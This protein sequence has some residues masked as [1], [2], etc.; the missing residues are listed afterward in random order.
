MRIAF[1][2]SFL[3]GLIKQAKVQQ[4]DPVKLAYIHGRCE[5]LNSPNI[6]AGFD[7]ALASYQGVVKK[8]TFAVALRP[9]VLA[10]AVEQVVQE[11]CGPISE[12]MRERLPDHI[13]LTEMYKEAAAQ[14]GRPAPD[15]F[16]SRFQRMKLSDKLAL[17]SS[18]GGATGAAA[19]TFFPSQADD[20]Y[21]RGPFSRAVR[22]GARGFGATAGG[23]LGLLAGNELGNR[24]DPTGKPHPLA[25]LAGA[26]IGGLAG[27]Q[28]A[29][30]VF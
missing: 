26:G 5:I 15:D 20:A 16:L 3:N 29:S 1:S 24:I 11:G 28:L 27:H 30:S 7:K 23:A 2:K 18:I 14:A 10:T 21:G 8:A 9:E 22:G 13:E 4:Q 25:A 6:R 12:Q 17:L 19:G